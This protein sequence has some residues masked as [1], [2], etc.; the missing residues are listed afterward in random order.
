VFTQIVYAVVPL[1]DHVPRIAGVNVTTLKRRM[2]APVVHID[3]RLQAAYS[4]L[5]RVVFP[6][7]FVVV[8]DVVI[9]NVV[10]VPELFELAAIL[11]LVLFA[12]VVVVIDLE[13]MIATAAV[14]VA[15]TKLEAT[16][17]GMLSR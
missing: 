10:E 1:A 5:L 3:H 17:L 15:A 14:A 2:V 8:I 16:G 6:V 9:L 11:G 12:A 13:A 7:V 4:V